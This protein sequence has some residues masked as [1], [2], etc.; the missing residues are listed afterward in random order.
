M[1]TPESVSLNRITAPATMVK[2]RAAELPPAPRS[3]WLSGAIRVYRVTAR[4][5]SR[6]NR[7][8]LTGR[9]IEREPVPAAVRVPES[10]K[11]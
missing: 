11:G 4:Q 2:L 8:T 1:T 10:V 3:E 7:A 6:T 9:V 5:A